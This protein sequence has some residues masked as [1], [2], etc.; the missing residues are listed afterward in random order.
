MFMRQGYKYLIAILLLSGCATFPVDGPHIYQP[1][2]VVRE[3]CPP[4]KWNDP[5]TPC[6]LPTKGEWYLI[7]T[8]GWPPPE[9][10]QAKWE[11]TLICIEGYS[12][13]C[14]EARCNVNTVGPAMPLTD[15]CK[16]TIPQDS[17][18][19]IRDCRSIDACLDSIV[20]GMER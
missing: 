9:V 1:D 20:W 5:T 15:S 8:F 6:Y 11:G 18:I 10:Y 3:L 17:T 2:N 12:M 14:S 19:Y 7:E 13:G 16:I 4:E